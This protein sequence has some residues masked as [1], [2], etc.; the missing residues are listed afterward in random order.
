MRLQQWILDEFDEM[1]ARLRTQVLALVPPERRHER[2]GG[3]NSINWAA[4]HVARHADLA[5]AIIDGGEPRR[6]GGFGLGEVEHV[7]PEPLDAAEVERYVLDVTADARD[8]ILTL[9]IGQLERMPDAARALE[10]AGV[11][12][13]EFAWL[14]EQWSGQTVAFFLRWPLTAHATNHIGEMIATRNLMGLSPYS[15]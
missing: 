11:P 5:L 2:P 1:S 15:S 3:G 13:G 10:L 14:Y 7:G 9:D 6:R 12:R 4:F 8:F